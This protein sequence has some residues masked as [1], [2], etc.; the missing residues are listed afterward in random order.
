MYSSTFLHK[1]KTIF[2]VTPTR[3]IR[4][5]VTGHEYRLLRTGRDTGGERLEMEVTYPVSSIKPPMH[6]HPMQT[7]H[8]RVVSGEMT[9]VM[10]GQQRVLKT[11]D[12]LDIPANKP[13]AMWNHTDQPAVMHW[14]VGPALQT[15]Q[16]FDTLAALANAGKTNPEGAPGLLQAALTMRHFSREFRLTNPPRLVQQVVFALLAPLAR[17]LGYRAAY[18]SE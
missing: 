13:H 4:N 9:V 1:T 10:D 2:M 18:P 11:G 12:T 6:Y 8:F 5:A 17:L 15:E 16:F 7:E 14:T 3:T